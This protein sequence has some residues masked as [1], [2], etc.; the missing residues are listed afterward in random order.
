M[1]E[2]Q[3]IANWV[4]NGT[5]PNG[6]QPDLNGTQIGVESGGGTGGSKSRWTQRPFH[7]KWGGAVAIANIVMAAA[8]TDKIAGVVGTQSE[9]TT[10]STSSFITISTT[11]SSPT[12]T[13]TPVTVSIPSV[14]TPT[15]S[16]FQIHDE[17]NEDLANIVS[18]NN[19]LANALVCFGETLVDLSSSGIAANN[20]A[21]GTATI[22]GNA[23]S[24]C[25]GIFS[26]SWEIW[27][28][29][30]CLDPLDAILSACSYNGGSI[31]AT[32]GTFHLQICPIGHICHI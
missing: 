3:T 20:W 32:C 18:T 24:E 17:P 21:F 30:L 6:T 9:P 8:I 28:E 26:K 25:Q 14:L 13:W 29:A 31:N 27:D 12:L 2:P 5:L 19:G 10:T 22:P 23:A 16:C 15:P 1:P 11:S 4:A 7:P